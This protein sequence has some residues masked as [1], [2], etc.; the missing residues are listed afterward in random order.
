MLASVA[1]LWFLCTRPNA[2]IVM[3]APSSNQLYNGMMMEIRKWYNKSILKDLKLFQ[4]TK[5]RIRLD[6]PDVMN[7]WFL[8]AVS[9][10]NPENISGVHAENVF[11]IV[12]EGA[13]VEDEI[14]VRLE[15]VLTTKGSYMITLGEWVA[16]VKC[17][18]RID[19]PVCH[20][21]C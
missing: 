5:D 12:D 17:C 2:R 13:G 16:Q 15:G 14:F 9:V 4:F 3:T 8:S 21:W 6:Y 11:A 7:T 19:N 10:A 18:E 20:E 1:A